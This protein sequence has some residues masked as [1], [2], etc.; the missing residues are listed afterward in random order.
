ME[1]CKCIN[2]KYVNWKLLIFSLIVISC[3]FKLDQDSTNRKV[4]QLFFDTYPFIISDSP[5]LDQKQVDGELLYYSYHDKINDT[6]INYSFRIS[7]YDSIV[8]IG[9]YAK[10]YQDELYMYNLLMKEDT[11]YFF[12]EDITNP[13]EKFF[14]VGK[15]GYLFMNF[16]FT[17][18]EIDYYMLYRDSLNK[19]R[20]NDLSRLPELNLE[21]RKRFEKLFD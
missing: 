6:L 2:S 8:A 7:K 16:G 13:S 4:L 17:D 9:N 15:Y 12:K 5:T 21:E 1:Y 20:G 10:Q 18:N 11:V 19:V 3:S 14:I